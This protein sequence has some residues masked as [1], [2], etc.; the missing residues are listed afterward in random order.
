[1][2]YLEHGAHRSWIE[3]ECQMWQHSLFRGAGLERRRRPPRNHGFDNVNPLRSVLGCAGVVT[4]HTRL[5]HDLL[6]RTRR[7]LHRGYRG[8]RCE[9][10]WADQPLRP[11]PAVPAPC[12]LSFPPPIHSPLGSQNPAQWTICQSMVRAISKSLIPGRLINF[13]VRNSAQMPFRACGYPHSVVAW[14]EVASAHA[15]LLELS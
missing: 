1:M 14:L 11:R 15:V 4:S 2:D 6:A 3:S 12:P 9:C 10:H 8:R 5:G 13:A 7:K